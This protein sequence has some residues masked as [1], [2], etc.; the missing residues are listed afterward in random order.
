MRKTNL[1]SA[2]NNS[3][4]FDGVFSV[5]VYIKNQQAILIDSGISKDVA[6]ELDKTLSHAGIHVAAIINTHCHG[7]HCGGNNFFQQKYPHLKIFC[8]EAERPFV[9]DPLMGPI[10]LCNGAAAYEE[11]QKCKPITPQQGSKVTD[12]ITPYQ[13]QTITICGEP[14]EII[15]LPGH[16]RGMIGVKT[17]DNVLYCSDAIFG[18]ETFRKHRILYYTFIGQALGSLKK[19]K[20]LLPSTDA[21]IIYH[22]GTSPTVATLIDDHEKRI[23]DTKNMVLSMVQEAPC[24]LEEITS[25]VMRIH[26]IPD[27]LVAYALTKTPLQAYIA[28]L[29]HEKLIKIRVTEGTCRAHI[30]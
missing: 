16:T 3:Y 14:F 22:G 8:T 10:G 12:T 18:E 24:S 11:I 4:Y 15:T 23:L 6:K 2:K 30:S 7:D 9:E 5:G 28:E 20:S 19:L 25:K 17:P 13:D 29:E 21:V 1:I 26:S 27:S